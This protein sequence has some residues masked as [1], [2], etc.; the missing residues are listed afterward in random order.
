MLV[1]F[2]FGGGGGCR[3]ITRVATGDEVYRQTAKHRHE[4]DEGCGQ[5]LFKRSFHALR[6]GAIEGIRNLDGQST[7]CTHDEAS[8][9]G[10]ELSHDVN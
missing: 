10:D 3:A 4:H 7:A 5:W 8:K 2:F 9:E 1:F 6:V